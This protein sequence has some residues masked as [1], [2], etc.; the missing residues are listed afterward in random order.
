MEV[1]KTHQSGKRDDV[2]VDFVGV[3]WEVWPRVRLHVLP[4]VGVVAGC[5]WRDVQ[6]RLV[7]RILRFLEG[8]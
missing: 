4:H 2:S 3:V 6:L 7:K 1:S 8:G 5:A